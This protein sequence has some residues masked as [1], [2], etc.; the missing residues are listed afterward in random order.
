MLVELRFN[1]KCAGRAK[2]GQWVMGLNSINRIVAGHMNMTMVCWKA[3][4]HLSRW[5]VWT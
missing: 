3:Q 4:M 5:N 2:V 1:G